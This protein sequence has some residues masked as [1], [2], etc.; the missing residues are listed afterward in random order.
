MKG[1]RIVGIRDLV[2]FKAFLT[3]V[4]CIGQPAHTTFILQD[5]AVLSQIKS[6][7][8]SGEEIGCAL[9]AYEKLLRSAEASLQVRNPSVVHKSLVP[10]SGDK[11]DYYSIS[12]YW[13]PDPS[14]PD[15]LPWIRR[16]G[17]TNPTSQNDAVDRDRLGTM[18]TMV[19]YLSLAYFFTE[20]E[21]F[22]KKAIDMINTW[23][24]SEGTRMN[25]HLAYA[26]RVPGFDK[27]RRAGILDGRLIALTI[28]DAI[29]FLRNSPEWSSAHERGMQGWFSE[30]LDWLTESELGMEAAMQVNN[31]GSWYRFHVA[32]IALFVG[33]DSVAKKM[34]LEV[35][36]SL[37]SQLNEDGA[38]IHELERTRSF[39]YSCFNLEPLLLLARIG[40]RLAIDL[41]NYESPSGKSI[42]LAVNYLIPVL[43]GQGWP[44]PSS[45]EDKFNHLIPILHELS[46]KTKKETYAQA[47]SQAVR[48]TG[49]VSPGD[50]IANRLLERCLVEGLDLKGY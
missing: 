19:K 34:V 13:W 8:K 33:R 21:R 9:Q 43:E 42:E 39:F 47:L 3:C 25:P 10:P 38:Q 16:D 20:D 6:K 17:Q 23:F 49:E 50:L 28:P 26:Q 15:S 32:A 18:T 45:E 27:G 31:H 36:E 5:V 48:L 40:D 35:Q 1:H 7:L 46:E 2:I 41:R 37:D 11:R 29:V 24:L 30:Y 44:H 14:K 12:R 22:A 4:Y